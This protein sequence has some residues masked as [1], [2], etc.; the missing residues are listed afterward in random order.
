MWEKDNKKKYKTYLENTECVYKKYKN[1]DE[2]G[3]EYVMKMNW[4]DME[5]IYW[6]NWEDMKKIWI[7]NRIGVQ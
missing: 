4:R 6:I 2:V 1:W 7:R 3:I 5:E